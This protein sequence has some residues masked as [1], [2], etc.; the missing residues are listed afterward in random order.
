MLAGSS[1]RSADAV[2]RDQVVLLQRR[3]PHRRLRAASARRCLARRGDRRGNAAGGR[4]AW[5]RRSCGWH[6]HDRRPR[7]V[8]A[9]VPQQR[10][11]TA[12]GVC[13]SAGKG[14]CEIW[15]CLL[16]LPLAP[17]IWMQFDGDPTSS[18]L[19]TMLS[20]CRLCWLSCK[21]FPEPNSR[22]Q[23]CL[24]VQLAFSPGN[25]T[26]SWQS[27]MYYPL[28]GLQQPPASAPQWFTAAFQV[29]EATRHAISPSVE[30]YHINQAGCCRSSCS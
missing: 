9:V 19:D 18:C 24:H 6:Q 1:G 20:Q 21:C 16:C 8:R 3:R 2:R 4:D 15:S 14:R 22:P 23:T 12:C 11:V 28:N 29:R 5:L 17:P 7:G 27:D 26:Y 13:S 10:P 25:D 30:A